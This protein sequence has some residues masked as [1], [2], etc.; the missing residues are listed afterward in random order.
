MFSTSLVLA[1]SVYSASSMFPEI[2]PLPNG[3]HPEGIATGRGTDFF[4][5]SLVAGAIYAGNLRTGQGSIL[6]QPQI[7]R[8]AVGLSVDQR[9]NFL[10]VA[11]GETGDAYVYNAETGAEVYVY[12]FADPP[13]FINDVV[14]T[15]EAAYFTDSFSPFLYRVPLGP[16]GL[17]YGQADVQQIPLGG[18]FVLVPGEFN[19]NGID[20]TPD[21]ESLLIVSSSPGKLYQVDPDS[22]HA[23]EVD[24]GGPSPLPSADGILLDGQTLY[25][26]QNF[27]NQIAVIKL[28]SDLVTGTIVGYIAN[29][30]FQIPT[31]A[32]KFGSALYAVN[33]RFDV[34]LP[35]PDAEFDMLRVEIRGNKAP[36]FHNKNAAMWGIIKTLH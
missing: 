17:P 15:R 31:T 12:Q 24:L 32:A 21:G 22:G 28:D 14:V 16:G 13:T 27:L 5:G 23:T 7:N 10:F 18:D 26:V 8:Q 29:P 34:P 1:A 6:I 35:T 20:A 3:F 25:V 4:V 11:G 30:N 9:S 2:I 33:A 19:S 36:G